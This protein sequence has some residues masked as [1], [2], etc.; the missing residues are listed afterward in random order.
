MRSKY[1][2][3]AMAASLA[4]AGCSNEEFGYEGNEVSKEDRISTKDLNL[5]FTK[6]DAQTRAQWD[7]TKDNTLKFYWT[8]AKDKDDNVID[9][10]G[11][12]YTGKSG[13]TG[14]T[15]YGF[16]VDSLQLASFKKKDGQGRWTG[17]YQIDEQLTAVQNAYTTED[18]NTLAQGDLGKSESAK[19]KTTN[20]YLMKGYYVAYYP[21]DSEYENAGELIPLKSP[22][23]IVITGTESSEQTNEVIL[24]ENLKAVG[25]KTYSYSKPAEIKEAGNQVTEFALQNLSSALRIRIANEG[26]TGITT[27]KKLKTVVLRTKGNDTFVVK[28]RLSN[29]SAAPA[30]NVINVDAT[31]GRTATLFARYAK[32]YYLTLAANKKASDKDTVDVY[33]PV[34]PT[35]FESDGIEVILIGEDNMACVLDAKFSKTGVTLPAGRRLNLYAKVTK[36]T[37]FDQAFITTAKDLQ[38][39]I[40]KAKVQLTP[41]TINLLGDIT[42]TNFKMEGTAE[43]D[44]K[45]NVIINASTGSKLT[46]ENPSISL[47]NTEEKG[48]QPVWLTINAPLAIKGNT[49]SI[50]GSVAL[51]GETT[52]EGNLA[53]GKATSATDFYSGQLAIGGKT[54]I[55]AGTTVTARYS[56]GVTIKKGGELVIEKGDTSKKIADGKFINDNWKYEGEGKQYKSDL[57]IEGTM[58]VNGTL[59]DGGDTQINGGKLVVNG[60]ATNWNTMN[61]NGGTIEVN[62]TFN[63][64][65]ADATESKLAKGGNVKIATGTLTINAN[66]KIYNKESLNCAG[67]FTN[68]GTF[69]DYVG[70]VY[71]GNPYT[72]NGTY[73]CYVNSMERL[74]EAYRRLNLV[75]KDK[76]QKII[77]QHVEDN[78]DVEFVYDLNS[79]SAAKVDFENEGDV[80]I[81]GV[82]VTAKNEKVVRLINSLTV[83]EGEVT[84]M[85]SIDIAGATI[86]GKT[87]KPVVINENSKLT[88]ENNL[89]VKVN[90][91]IENNAKGVFNLKNAEK[92]TNLPATVYCKSANVTVG[93]WTNYPSIYADGSFWE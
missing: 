17:F 20:D 70:S 59:E 27:A 14:V 22:K 49:S 1:L 36:D 28:G 81:N 86:A 82:Y 84:I 19:F 89:E 3:Y 39:A 47:F 7:E 4:L 43:A 62:G 63:N 33:F 25:E 38:D 40:D 29:P 83:N 79:E 69:Y 30:A 60:T 10:I 78:G 64:E 57:I 9:K 21:F 85:G 72:S 58:T 15:N 54:T 42:S 35:T 46:L 75:A 77:L 11:M 66:G 23:E 32:N 8:D 26:E 87:V 51:N 88:I 2:F 74:N 80:R 61:V 90:G 44:W 16:E 41:T 48:K 45:G 91:A 12:V 71:G 31:E 18:G 93:A 52:I 13:T 53:I 67:T 65:K 68:N 55:K 76:S 34:L 73:A 24:K 6:A 92:D 50:Q 5:V 56:K 37:Q